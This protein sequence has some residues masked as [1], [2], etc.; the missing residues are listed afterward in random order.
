MQIDDTPSTVCFLVLPARPESVRT[1]RRFVAGIATPW[2]LDPE[3]ISQVVS[4]LV[5]NVVQHT[6]CDRV[7]V[8][9]TRTRSG[10]LVDVTDQ[11]T[12]HLPDLSAPATPASRLPSSSGRGLA[13][14]RA[15]ADDLQL[16][17]STTEKT[18]RASFARRVAS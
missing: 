12:A 16:I 2:G 10:V 11:D 18:V 6:E 3:P 1:A 8:S 17:H 7:S 5:T 15:F 13:I 4:E 14:A 9:V